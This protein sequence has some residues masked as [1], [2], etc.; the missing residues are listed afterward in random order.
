M[1]RHSKRSGPV[2]G[3]V[4]MLLWASA[5]QTRVHDEPPSSAKPLR[6]HRI[7]QTLRAAKGYLYG[8]SNS[9]FAVIH[10]KILGA[11]PGTKSMVESYLSQTHLHDDGD[12]IVKGHRDFGTGSTVRVQF[13]IE[14]VESPDLGVPAE[15][16]EI[17]TSSK[18]ERQRVLVINP[19]QIVVAALD[20]ARESR[21]SIGRHVN[22]SPAW[23]SV[24]V[25]ADISRVCDASSIDGPLSTLEFYMDLP[26]S[27]KSRRDLFNL[28][29]FLEGMEQAMKTQIP[30]V[31]CACR[32]LL[33][34]YF[35]RLPEHDRGEH[36][37][38]PGQQFVVVHRGRL[39]GPQ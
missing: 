33:D 25:L 15:E 22:N 32:T 10:V 3:N 6:V 37:A 2:K 21:F 36:A 20:L 26:Y 16:L 39:S 35:A 19:A 5:V 29:G 27:G 11:A 17:A 23:Q 4:P 18:G 7:D 34:V 31:A 1:T 12:A 38:P 8:G 9:S 14:L 28:E 30:V 13:V 24:I